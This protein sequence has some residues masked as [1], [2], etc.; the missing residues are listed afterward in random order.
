MTETAHIVES[1]QSLESMLSDVPLQ[2]SVELGRITLSLRE[3]AERLTPGAVVSLGKVAGE[4]LDIRINDR[5]IARGEAVAVGDR[6]GIRITD[7]LSDDTR[8]R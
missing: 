1:P 2:I 8:A 6:Y 3:V 7:V 5:L 4:K